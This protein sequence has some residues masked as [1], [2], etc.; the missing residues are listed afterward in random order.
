M[1]PDSPT[2]TPATR[3][4]DPEL[5]AVAGSSQIARGRRIVGSDYSNT[6]IPARFADVDGTVRIGWPIEPGGLGGWSDGTDRSPGY[7]GR[8]LRAE[9]GAATRDVPR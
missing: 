8:D 6:Y 7:V 4:Q 2:D 9:I 3:D 5:F 1:R